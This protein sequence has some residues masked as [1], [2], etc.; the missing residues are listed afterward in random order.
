MEISEQYEIDISLVC[1]ILFGGVFRLHCIDTMC[2][3]RER[4]Y[5]S[6]RRLATYTDIYIYGIVEDRYCVME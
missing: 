6:A 3:L 2:L 5:A 4:L 1:N